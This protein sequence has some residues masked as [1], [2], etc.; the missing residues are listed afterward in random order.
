MAAGLLLGGLTSVVIALLAETT[1][2]RALCVAVAGLFAV[3]VVVTRDRIRFCLAA[4]IFLIP[5]NI[6]YY[7]FGLYS[8]HIGGAIGLYLLPLD[9]PLAYLIGT[10]FL[11]WTTGTGMGIPRLPRAL[12]FFL[13]F[14]AIEAISLV[15]A[16]RPSWALYELVRW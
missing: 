11:E 15:Y 14:L 5:L 9:L 7:L 1:L 8:F 6:N 4:L 16:I 3:M 10:W 13:P 2:K 12:R